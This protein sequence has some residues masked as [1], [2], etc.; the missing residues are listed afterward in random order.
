MP[1]PA[2]GILRFKTLAGIRVG[3]GR[4]YQYLPWVTDILD[5]PAPTGI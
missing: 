2:F 1:L 3:W 5:K 4:V